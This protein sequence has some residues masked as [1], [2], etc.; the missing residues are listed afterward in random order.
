MLPTICQLTP[1]DYP[2]WAALLSVAF[3]RPHD[4]MAALLRWL[5]TVQPLVAYGA[6]LDGQL[7]A[8]Y[9][10]ALR[11]MRLGDQTLRVGMSINMATH[12][13]YRGRGLVKQVAAPVYAHLAA[14]GLCAGVGFSNAAGVRVDRHSKGYGYRVVGPMQALLALPARRRDPDALFFCE[15]LPALPPFAPREGLHFVADPHSLARRYAA[16]PSRR[17]RF[18][19]WCEAGEVLGVV[20]DRP[21]RLRG[22]AAASLFD[23]QVTQ[24][25]P[26]AALLRRYLRAVPDAHLIHAVTSP[27]AALRHALRANAFCW[28]LPRP[29]TPYF[30]TAKP[31][32][33]T[34]PSALTDLSAWDAVGGDVL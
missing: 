19:L 25:V 27:N 15:M 17:Y 11:Q 5:P 6:W 22:I 16:H 13:D 12:P 28:T 24:G 4:E 33:D 29:R 2:D 7:V 34:A 10:C 1:A 3:G 18:G 23:V 30:I 26:L 9:A 32:N 20:V 8:Q 14:A 21:T 31:L